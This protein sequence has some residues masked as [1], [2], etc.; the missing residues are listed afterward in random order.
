MEL[1]F[2]PWWTQ[3]SFQWWRTVNFP[4][5]CLFIKH[6]HK[7][8]SFYYVVETDKQNIK[9]KL[10]EKTCVVNLNF[11]NNNSYLK[12]RPLGEFI[13]FLSTSFLEDLKLF[14]SQVGSILVPI[15]LSCRWHLYLNLRNRLNSL[16]HEFY[17]FLSFLG[18]IFFCF[19]IFRKKWWC[20][21]FYF[22][23]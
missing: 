6:F 8:I 5:N 18:K 1:C 4:L 14:N 21:V 11:G 2:C 22:W 7:N 23:I 12:S 10:K 9:Q 16:L 20:A 3:P 17:L 13:K 15:C 19:F